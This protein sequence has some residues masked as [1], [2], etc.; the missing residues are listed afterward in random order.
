MVTGFVTLRQI[1]DPHGLA[2]PCLTQ[3]R[4]AS[5]WKQACP[6][7]R[8]PPHLAKRLLEEE[9]TDAVTRHAIEDVL[10]AADA[11]WRFRHVYNHR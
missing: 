2:F 3:R 8:E 5:A 11:E 4:T 9:L 7:C 1:V 6:R 10:W